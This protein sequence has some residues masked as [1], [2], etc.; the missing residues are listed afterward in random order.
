M[1]RKVDPAKRE[2]ILLA[3]RELFKVKGVADTTIAEIA[4]NAGIATG[5][6]Y[7]YFKSKMDIVEGLCDYYLL[8]HLKA[9]EPKFDN[10]PQKAITDVIHAALKHASENADLVRLIDLRRSIRGMA[11]RP[12]ADKVIQKALRRGL[13]RYIEEG[14]VIPYNPAVLAEMVGGLVEWVCKICFVWSDVDPL[15]YENTLIELLNHALI[16]DYKQE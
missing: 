5:T 3:A 10:S 7:L 2:A 12:E 8:S 14:I 16:K 1:A 9:I 6:V 13:R 11:P 4:G 15:R